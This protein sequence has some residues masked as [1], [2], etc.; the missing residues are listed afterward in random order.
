MKSKILHQKQHRISWADDVFHTVFMKWLWM[1][2]R[3]SIFHNSS[4][5]HFLVRK[6]LRD[7]KKKK[8]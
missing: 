6:N 4:F 5:S 8:L 3:G 2:Y 7:L 1:A